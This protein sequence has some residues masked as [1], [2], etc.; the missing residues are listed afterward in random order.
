MANK[1]IDELAAKTP[2]ITDILPVADPSTGIAGKSTIAQV[3]DAKNI[4]YPTE[5]QYSITGSTSDPVWV[6]VSPRVVQID[7]GS[8]YTARGIWIDSFSGNANYLDNGSQSLQVSNVVGS[9]GISIS[10]YQSLTSVSFPELLIVNGNFSLSSLNS[11]TNLSLPKL[12]VVSQTFNPQ[13]ASSLTTLSLPELVHALNFTPSNMGALTSISI[14]KLKKVGTF[15]PSSMA[16]LTT[17]SLPELVEAASIGL[18]NMASLTTFSIPKL[19]SIVNDIQVSGLTLLTTLSFP[20]VIDIGSLV[21]ISTSPALTTV[22][23]PKVEVIA[24]K[25]TAGNAISFS[26]GTDSL[27]TFTLSPTLKRVG[28]NG[29]NVIFTSC[30][31]N[32]ASVDGILVRLAALD[33]TGVTTAFSNRTVTITGTSATPSATGLAA[34]ATLVARGCTV[35]HN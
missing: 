28:S 12:S 31:L 29:G 32:Q 30:S 15:N 17:L 26:N 1:R 27:T 3:T 25:T 21:A 8:V 19:S 7:S 33:G 20:E 24:G 13:N 14:P 2:A 23:F 22:S 11:L 6:Q 35:N 4:N 34:K 10:S 5:I 18:N 9:L 16:V